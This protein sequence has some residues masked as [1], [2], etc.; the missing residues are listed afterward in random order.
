MARCIMA[1]QY[2]RKVIRETFLQMLGEMPL[3]KITVK[4]IVLRCN[5]NRNTFYYHYADIYAV[6]TEVLEMDLQRVID[7][8]NDTMSWEE[9]CLSAARMALDN[10]RAVYHIYNSI[11]REKLERYMYGVAGSVMTRYV[12]HV[13]AGIP[14]SE[15]DKRIIARLYQSAMTEMVIQWIIGGM[16]EDPEVAIRR[17]G[18]LFDGNIVMSLKRSAGMMK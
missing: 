8:Y 2:T 16:K 18:Q 10:K 6:L 9:S 4:D 11:R 1:Q 12:E 14:A 7:E 5:I 15:G 3:D 17:I 13:S